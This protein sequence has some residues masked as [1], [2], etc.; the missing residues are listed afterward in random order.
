MQAHPDVALLA[1]VPA[2]FLP[3]G[4]DLCANPRKGKVAFGSSAWELFE[5]LDKERD[6]LPVL[7][8]IYASHTDSHAPLA[9]WSGYY[10]GYV[11]GVG[12]AHPDGRKIRPVTAVQ[13]GDEE[14]PWALY[15]EVADLKPMDAPV[16]IGGLRGYRAKKNLEPSRPKGPIIIKRP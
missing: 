13:D 5:E 12:G 11:R 1:P 2:V 3:E 14:G 9:T 6:G 8:L 4:A 10:V 16:P 7:V 15:W